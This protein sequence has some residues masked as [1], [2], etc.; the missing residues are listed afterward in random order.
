MIDFNEKL[1]HLFAEWHAFAKQQGDKFFVKDGLMYKPGAMGVQELWEKSPK[2]IVF[3]LKDQNQPNGFWNDDSRSW[4]LANENLR[5]L[6][7][8]AG[9]FFGNIA[10]LLWGITNMQTGD[11]CWFDEVTHVD[12]VSFFNA[13]PFAYIETKKLPG[14]AKLPP[15][16][17]QTH[18]DKYGSFLSRELDILQPH[19]FVCCSQ[20]VFHWV[21]THYFHG[22]AIHVNKNVYFDENTGSIILYVSHPASRSS[23]QKY[24][25]DN[26]YWYREYL[27][28]K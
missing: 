3:L 17:E 8:D 11:D 6:V 10:H 13:E 5:N 24:Y 25:E 28:N 7:G 12:L 9:K 27:R 18:L 20:K 4:P 14:G 26:I 15:K 19:T 22:K 2:R 16:I 23:A 1:E 21:V